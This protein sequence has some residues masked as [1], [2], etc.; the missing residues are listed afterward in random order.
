MAAQRSPPRPV[1]DPRSGPI[2]A[3]GALG[4][5]P[6]FA[7]TDRPA[8]A[9]RQQADRSDTVPAPDLRRAAEQTAVQAVPKRRPTTRQ[10]AGPAVA[11]WLLAACATEPSP[12]L[13]P[14]AATQV[15]RDAAGNIEAAAIRPAPGA[16]VPP[17]VKPV[18]PVSCRHFRRCP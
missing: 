17:L 7:C 13:Y 15:P 2:A 18:R 11:L 14:V 16:P 3:T 4:Q 5:P 8:S 1:I 6:L 9:N 12:P 10:I